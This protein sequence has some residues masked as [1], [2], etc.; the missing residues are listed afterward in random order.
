M[1]NRERFHLTM[2]GDGS[3]DRCPIIEW[4]TW[5]DKTIKCWEK[6]KM[7]KGMTSMELFDYFD[8]DR[9]CQFWFKHRKRNC[10]K[11]KWHGAPLIKSPDDYKQIKKYILPDNAVK[12]ELAKF[13]E[14]RTDIEN[15]ETIL[16]YTLEG[17]FWF[18]RTLLGIEGHMYAFYDMPELYHEICKDLLEWH[19]GVVEAF[20]EIAA[21]DFMTF[22]EDMSYNLGPM[23][24][25]ECFEEF[26]EPY[27]KQL[28]PEI[29]KR[30]TRVILDSDG[31]IS[32]AVPWF[33]GAGIEGIL[34]LER[35]AGVDIAALQKKF[36]DF[37]WLGGFDKMSLLEGKAAIDGEFE[38]LR[39]AIRRGKYIPSVDHQTPP[40]VSVEN[41]RYYV[42]KL[43][44]FCKQACKGKNPR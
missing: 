27:Y 40:G 5:W 34:P 9:H 14:N 39:P 29:K 36:P 20:S 35:Q 26:I 16:W 18:P 2:N 43:E 41:Y 25:R 17:F 21:A 13:M 37:L 19:F 8:L 32:S 31:D 24:S 22:A 38:R 6:E 4:A 1:T 3:V 15:G 10:P 33:I 42:K 7:P 12:R 11:P 44:H 28:I 30:G 23:I